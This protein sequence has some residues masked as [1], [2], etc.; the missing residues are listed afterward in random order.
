MKINNIK[1]NFSRNNPY[2]LVMQCQSGTFAEG[3]Y[4]TGN[5]VSGRSSRSGYVAL[6][7][8]DFQ[9]V[10]E[11]AV[12]ID[13]RM[14]EF[15]KQVKLYAKT[16]MVD[17]SFK[18]KTIER[19]LGETQQV[20]SLPDNATSLDNISLDLYVDIYRKEGAKIGRWLNNRIVWE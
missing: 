16:P 13:A 10:C 14:F 18:E 5:K 3:V 1:I 17:V 8:F 6:E 19:F 12:V 11:G 7:N 15:H 9:G 4:Y 20:T 2:M